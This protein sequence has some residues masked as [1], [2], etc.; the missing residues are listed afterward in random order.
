M[1]NVESYSDLK[2]GE[3]YY[4]KISGINQINYQVL[5]NQ[6][7]TLTTQE[8]KLP[9]IGD[10]NIEEI[11]SSLASVNFSGSQYMGK[12]DGAEIMTLSKEKRIEY[13][14]IEEVLKDEFQFKLRDA[15]WNLSNY[16][17]SLLKIESQINSK[18]DEINEYYFEIK[19][20]I[21][22]AKLNST[23]TSLSLDDKITTAS[24]IR[25]QLS[26]IVIPI[27]NDNTWNDFLKLEESLRIILGSYDFENLEDG[28]KERYKFNEA[29]FQELVKQKGV[30]LDNIKALKGSLVAAVNS[31]TGEDWEKSMNK[32]SFIQNLQNRDYY[33]LPIQYLGERN[34]TTISLILRD[35]EYKLNSYSTTFVFPLEKTP[36]FGVSSSFYISGLQSEVFSIKGNIEGDT[37]SN[38]SVIKEDGGNVEVGTAI[39]AK[40]G[41]KFNNNLG[42]H[43]SL[44]AGI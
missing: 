35:P 30:V 3:F 38:Y 14:R 25:D 34:K 42:G 24:Q 29:S 39:L 7:D 22:S 9:S 11:T 37:V 36:Y 40:F 13:K 20:S 31:I 10:F 32:V 4:I 41:K 23:Q 1:K 43:F 12:S 6:K 5:I 2:I 8:L 16:N 27:E 18:L 15:R 21:I 17:N 33:S 26:A 19:K 44:G 28:L